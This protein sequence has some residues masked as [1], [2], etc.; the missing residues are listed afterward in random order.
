MAIKTPELSLARVNMNEAPEQFDR[1]R[2][3]KP[4]VLNP[5][6]ECESFQALGSTLVK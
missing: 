1:S 6:W 2:K 4:A 3:S 5:S